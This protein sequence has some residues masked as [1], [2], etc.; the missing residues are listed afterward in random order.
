[1]AVEVVLRTRGREE[2]EGSALQS[3]A[4][5]SKQR[6]GL[7]PWVVY[8]IMDGHLRALH[9]CLTALHPCRSH[10]APARRV[11]TQL[12]IARQPWQLPA[13][14]SPPHDVQQGRQP[15]GRP[16]SPPLVALWVLR[17]VAG[18]LVGDHDGDGLG[19][20]AVTRGVVEDGQLVA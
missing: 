16:P 2:I 15:Q 14:T 3:G 9:P 11:A 13:G 7:W 8:C 5:G 20:D 6:W 4:V 10:G 18:A 1:M 19:G 12:A 17:L